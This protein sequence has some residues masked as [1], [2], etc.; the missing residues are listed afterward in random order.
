MSRFES[1][2]Q[3]RE[4]IERIF[5]MMNDH[6]EIGPKLHAA[7]AP[8]LFDFSDFDLHF[9]VTH[10]SPEEAERGRYLRWTWND[11]EVD[12]EPL[13]SLRMDSEVAN[14]YFQG[15][16]NIPMAVAT[17]KISVR[18]PIGKILELAP[19]TKPVFAKYRE[20]LEDEGPENL[21]V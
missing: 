3:F 21:L 1:P 15:K 10:T 14:R 8:H 11:D 16:I 20:W 18:G 6:P 5:R 4:V 12:W 2:E 19:I 9:H 17:G 13:I 7:K